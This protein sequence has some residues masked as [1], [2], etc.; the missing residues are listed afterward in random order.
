MRDLPFQLRNHKPLGA[1]RP[2]IDRTGLTGSL[3]L[4]FDMESI[5]A[6]FAHGNG[7]PTNQ[8]IY[9]ATVDALDDQLGLTLTP[10]KAPVEIL[11]V[12]HAEKPSAN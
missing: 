12:D 9:N 6:T 1:D 10:M 3:G 7:P 4:D 5:M 2:I 8:D 11:V